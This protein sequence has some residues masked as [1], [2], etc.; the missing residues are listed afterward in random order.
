VTA[1]AFAALLGCDGSEPHYELD[2]GKSKP[3]PAFELADVKLDS[4]T[5]ARWWTFPDGAVPDY[6]EYYPC[7]DCH[8]EDTPPDG[9]VR[10]L[11]DEHDDLELKHGDGKIWCLSCHHIDNRDA[12]TDNAGRELPH[13]RPDRVCAGCHAKQ[14]RDFEHGVHG[15]RVGNRRDERKL[16]P[17]TA[18]HDPHAPAIVPRKPLPAPAPARRGGGEP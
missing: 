7:I 5:T 18:C 14:H 12:Y 3:A 16:T 13:D 6:D 15:K 17:C 9:S 11:I 10:T 2:R 4:H 8:D 1:A